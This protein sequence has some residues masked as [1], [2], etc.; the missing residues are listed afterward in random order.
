MNKRKMATVWMGALVI[1]LLL[2]GGS[3]MAGRNK[4]F[5][6]GMGQGNPPCFASLSADQQKQFTELRQK[7][8]NDTAT[9]RQ[10]IA[11]KRAALNLELTKATPDVNNAQSIQKELSSLE[12]QMEQKQVA[13]MIE[14]KKIC[15][16]IG[17][18]MGRMHGGAMMGRGM[19]GQG[20][21]GAPQAQ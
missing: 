20:M 2:W 11:E 3:A 6:Q 17:T 4:G 19:M 14:M 18:G 16:T 5:G 8:F 1:G 21:M 13:H 7:F 9:L 12:A 15:P 10:Q